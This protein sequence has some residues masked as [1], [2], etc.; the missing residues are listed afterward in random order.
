MHDLKD[1]SCIQFFC[2]VWSLAMIILPI[3]FLITEKMVWLLIFVGLI[4]LVIIIA[5]LQQKWDKELEGLA[6][7][8]MNHWNLTPSYDTIRYYKNLPKRKEKIH[9]EYCQECRKETE[10]CSNG[11]CMICVGKETYGNGRCYC[12]HCLKCYGWAGGNEC[13]VCSSD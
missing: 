12:G 6:Q 4:V 9:K 10:R 3:I 7:S 11:H 5:K 2:C 13:S 8:G 1:D